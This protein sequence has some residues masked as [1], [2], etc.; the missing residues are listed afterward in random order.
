ML[1]VSFEDA[2]AMPPA[3]IPTVITTALPAGRRVIND[4]A[5]IG[6][7]IPLFPVDREMRLA[8]VADARAAAPNRV[9]WTACFMK[10]YAVVAAEMPLLRTWF[11]DGLTARL[12]TANHSVASLAINRAEPD[13]DRLF[14]ARLLA[15]DVRPLVGIQ[16]FIDRHTMAPISE[17]FFKQLDLE[18]M[19]GWLRRRI[20]RWNMNSSSPK[21]A[22][23]I[24]TF[25]MSSLAGS[26]V[27]NHFHPTICTT[28][29]CQ[30]PLDDAGRC[31]VTIIA[32]HRVLD[33]ITVAK[34]L[35]RLEE[36][37][38]RDIATELKSLQAGSD[39]TPAA[40]A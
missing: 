12:A 4:L 23:R 8:D 40:A 15:P 37:L 25:S 19:P 13:G 9:G 27:G 18:R 39:A 21:R 5:L 14:V 32:D 38:V 11:I 6:R 2:L 34:A 22:T 3:T 33:G 17:V 24:G 36:V 26:G 31:R 20:L 29:L 16:S 1:S 7:S 28:S 10:A 30:G 35:Q